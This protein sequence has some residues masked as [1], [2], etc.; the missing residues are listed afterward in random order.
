MSRVSGKPY[1]VYVL[2]SVSGSCFYIGISENPPVREK[3]H[4][5]GTFKS[6]TKRYRPWALVFSEQHP[7]YKSAKK[8]E[9]E[10]KAQKGGKGFFAKTGLDPKRFERDSA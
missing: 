9:N 2:W 7:D 6:W 4:S 10:L 3:Q 5:A 1:F 8:R